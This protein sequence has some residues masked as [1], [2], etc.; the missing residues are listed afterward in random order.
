VKVPHTREKVAEETAGDRFADAPL[1]TENLEQLTDLGLLHDKTYE[2][3]VMYNIVQIDKQ[4][5]RQGF[6]DPDFPLEAIESVLVGEKLPVSHLACVEH[7]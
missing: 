1:I 5:M 7:V 4:G 2:L 3:G 6:E